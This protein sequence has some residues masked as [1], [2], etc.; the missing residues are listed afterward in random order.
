MTYATYIYVYIYKNFELIYIFTIISI[1][2][3]YHISALH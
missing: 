3:I 1:I 2:S